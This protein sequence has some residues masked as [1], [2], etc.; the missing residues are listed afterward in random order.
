MK[1]FQACI[2]GLSSCRRL[3]VASQSTADTT[4]LHQPFVNK[5]AAIY[6]SEVDFSPGAMGPPA[7]EPRH[8][9]DC[10]WQTKRYP[11]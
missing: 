4:A 7:F 11:R 10:R 3:V 9:H 5:I 8:F 2:R 6:D 1:A